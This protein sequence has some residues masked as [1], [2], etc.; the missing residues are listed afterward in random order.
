MEKKR[1]PQ[2]ERRKLQ[3]GKLTSK[4]KDTVKVGNHPHTNISKPT[5]VRRGVQMQD[6]G[7]YEISNLKQSCMYVYTY[8][9]TSPYIYIWTAVRKPHGNHKPK[10]YSR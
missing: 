5:I 8:I 7:N 2:L 3:M 9:H 10:I 6:I 1:R 4:G